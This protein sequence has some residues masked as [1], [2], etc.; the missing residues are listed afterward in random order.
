MAHSRLAVLF[1]VALNVTAKG[2][3]DNVVKLFSLSLKPIE[4]VGINVHC[5]WHLRPWHS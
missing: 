3:V 4:K 2:S 1:L 5:D